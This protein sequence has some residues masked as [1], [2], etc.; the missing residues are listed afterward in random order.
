MKR[1][2]SRLVRGTHIVS[3]FNFQFNVIKGMTRTNAH[4]L[5]IW[6]LAGLLAGSSLTF[7]NCSGKKESSEESS[8]ATTA[9]SSVMGRQGDTLNSSPNDV[10]QQAPP[11]SASA[12]GGVMPAEVKVKPQN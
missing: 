2:A 11:D 9:D 4:H 7:W 6:L 1:D 8:S 12:G 3:I 5:R 10:S